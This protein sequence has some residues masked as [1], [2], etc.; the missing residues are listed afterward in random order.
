MPSSVA[1]VFA[2]A[3]L[4]PEGV[5]RWGM[6]LPDERSGVY[7]VALTD[8]SASLEGTL[9][10]VPIS[11]AAIAELLVVRPELTLDGRRPS[12]EKLA[13]RIG[14]FWFPDE[15]IVYIG[16]AT[17]L[18]SR[19]RGYYTTPLG[20]RRPHAGGWFLKTLSNL[21]QLY[22]HFARVAEFDDAECAM[23]EAFVAGVSPATCAQ[24]A[25]PAHPWPFANLEIRRDGRKIRK[26]HGI[27]GA[28]GDLA[29]PAP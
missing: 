22:V 8:A 9:P 26:V 23:L 27:R 7:A 6:P 29:A 5:V 15:P 14:A 25:D 12:A 28:R 2:A 16:L 24:L 21:D 11:A 13:A 17:S 10:A 18:R 20:A 3:G 19:V 1:A 4:E